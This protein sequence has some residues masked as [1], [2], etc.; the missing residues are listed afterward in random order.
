MKPDCLEDAGKSSHRRLVDTVTAQWEARGA[1]AMSVRQIG[2]QAEAPASSIYHHFGSLERLFQASQREWLDAA[3]RWCD[4]QLEQLSCFHGS[5]DG[6]GGFFAQIVDEWAHAHRRLA[7]AWRECHLLAGRSADFASLAERWRDLWTQFWH[8]AGQ[9]FSLGSSILVAARVFD[10]ESLLHLLRW[11]RNA[12]RAALDE[13]GRGIAAWLSGRPAPPAPWRDFAHAQA[14]QSM[15][16][17]PAGDQVVMQIRRAAADLVGRAGAAGVTHRAV[18]EQAGLTLGTVSH[19]FRTKSALLEAAFEG[20]YL[21]LTAGLAM[22]NE[23]PERAGVESLVDDVMQLIGRSN[24]AGGSDE[25]FVAVARDPSLADF[26]AQLRY[27]RGRSSRATLQ[28]LLGAGRT[29]SILEGAMFSSVLSSQMR[30][31]AGKPTQAVRD[32][33]ESELNLVARLVRG[34]AVA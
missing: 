23:S 28:S 9:H 15:P 1:A 33:V 25:L 13:T 12:D 2:Q 17:A 20:T 5:P 19:K 30:E 14:V 32:K 11:R 7:F 10:S 8:E 6:F 3:H 18:A 26:G 4:A 21:A 34:D 29:A 27:L 16:Q 24:G 22:Q 31:F